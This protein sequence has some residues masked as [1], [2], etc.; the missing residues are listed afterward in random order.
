MTF[1][2]ATIS[3]VSAWLNE[4]QPPLSRVMPPRARALSASEQHVIQKREKFLNV[5][6]GTVQQKYT[7]ACAFSL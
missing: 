6:Q 5:L 7:K 2:S 3:R 4:V 1:N